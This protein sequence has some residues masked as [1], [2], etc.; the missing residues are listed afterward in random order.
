MPMDVGNEYKCYA[1]ILHMYPESQSTAAE[2][3][4]GGSSSGRLL[5]ARAAAA[6][7]ARATAQ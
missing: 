5:V 6:E 2:R 4:C 3:K 7:A 1:Y